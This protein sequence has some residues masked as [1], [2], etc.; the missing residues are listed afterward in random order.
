MRQPISVIDAS[1][2]SIFPNFREIIAYKDLFITLSWRDIRV[3]YAQ[4]FLGLLWAFIQPI[5]SIAILYLVFVRF[6]QIDTGNTPPLLFVACGQS[7]WTYFSFVISNSGKSI[8]ANENMIKKIYF[9]RLII[10]LS[11]ATT[12]LIDF[13]IALLVMI[14]LFFYYGITPSPYFMFSFVFLLFA[15]IASLGIGIWLSALTIRYRDFQYIIPFMVQI[16][17]YVT[18]V[19]YPAAFA[20]DNLPNW[21][22]T[23]YFLNPM[24]GIIEGFRWSL[25]GGT[26]P[27]GMTFISFG[28]VLILFVSSLYYFNKV[29]RT[30]ADLL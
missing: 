17:T 11:K 5:V 6:A 8:I 26:P 24:A 2:T 12:G 23:L 28:V 29:E 15:I 14:G 9:P 22:S 16:G 25:F 18:P 30:M 27:D 3:R 10:P 7:L 13:G 4:A 1:I 20:R 19:A 21:A